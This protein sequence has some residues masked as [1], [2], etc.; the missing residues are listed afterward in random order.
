LEYGHHPASIVDDA[1]ET[2][3]RFLRKY[4][5]REVITVEDFV[6][7]RGV[8]PVVLAHMSESVRRDVFPEVPSTTA[9]TGSGRQVCPPSGEMVDA[10]RAY[11]ASLLAINDLRAARQSPEPGDGDLGVLR[12]AERYGHWRFDAL[13]RE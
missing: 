10:A 1:D 12:L 6:G 11:R 4:Y 9:H 13:L 8:G 3:A 5:D 7:G 2:V